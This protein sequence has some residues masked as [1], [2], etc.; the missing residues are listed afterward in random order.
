MTEL[1]LEADLGDGDDVL[2]AERG[3]TATV[4]AG[5]GNDEVDA[6]GRVDGGPGNDS[7]RGADPFRGRLR[8]SGGPG[9][10]TLIGHY[11]PEL[12]VG[13]AGRDHFE[14]RGTSGVSGHD[15]DVVDARDGE[16]DEVSCASSERV[17]RLLLDGV[18]WPRRDRRGRCNGLRR[19]SP[20]R[21]LPADIYSAPE[22]LGDGT[23]VSVYCP[24]DVPRRCTGTISAV[25]E[26]DRLGPAGFRLR[27]GRR[28]DFKVARAE[29][30]D[31]SCDHD[32]PA[33]VTVRTRRA[34]RTLPANADLVILSCLH[35]SS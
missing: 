27:P 35:D 3:L 20:A 32:F 18:D 28:D 33:R 14:L 2:L 25:V 15:P 8:L 17:D 26:G 31:P 22:E 12:L 6:P 16:L 23:W 29:Y 34:G 24:H 5:E 19:A 4:R 10:D 9:D 30:D 1:R 21:A 13:G 7:L 11:G